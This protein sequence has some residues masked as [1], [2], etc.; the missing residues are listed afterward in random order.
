MVRYAESRGHEFDPVIPNAWQ[1][2]D[3]VIRALN[4]DVPYNQFVLE[5]L[6]GDLVAKPRP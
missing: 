1:Y 2:R 5:H 4:S 3:Y 6:A